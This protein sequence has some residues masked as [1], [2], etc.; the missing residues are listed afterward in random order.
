MTANP[1]GQ[2]ARRDLEELML[3]ERFLRFLSTVLETAGIHTGAYGSDGRHLV[4]AEGR[5]SL[6]FDILRSAETIRPDALLA[7]LQAELNALKG[8]P[9]GRPS[10]DRNHELDTDDDG[11][12][13]ADGR[14]PG[15]GLVFADYS[16]DADD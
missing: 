3:D 11:P 7:I 9:D 13:G 8:H 14:D 6:G 5:R 1:R 10:Y 15:T 12:V 2:L 16:R 4:F